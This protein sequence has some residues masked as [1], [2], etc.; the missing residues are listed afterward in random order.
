MPERS[1]RSL[2]YETLEGRQVAAAD[3]TIP[4]EIRTLIQ[5]VIT[6]TAPDAGWRA[7][8]GAEATSANLQSYANHV[9][10]RG[11]DGMVRG[12]RATVTPANPA[13]TVSATVFRG[14]DI[15]ATVPVPAAGVFT[16]E[17][18]IGFTDVLF[19]PSDRTPVQ[20]T[21]L[22]ASVLASMQDAS[23]DALTQFT[24]P[25]YALAAAPSVPMA[26]NVAAAAKTLNLLSSP[27]GNGDKR[28]YIERDPSQYT[29]V[30]INYT[31]GSGSIAWVG[32]IMKT[33]VDYMGRETVTTSGF[34]E[35]YVRQIDPNT[36]VIAPG[37]PRLLSF[38][39]WMVGATGSVSTKQGATMESVLPPAAMGPETVDVSM[40][41][42]YEQHQ[43]EGVFPGVT[44]IREGE[45]PVFSAPGHIANVKY[46]VRNEAMGGGTLWFDVYAGWYAG[47]PERGTLQKTLTASIGGGQSLMLSANVRAPSTPADATSDRPIVSI[48]TRFAGG[49]TE[50]N[51]RLGKLARH[52]PDGSSASDRDRLAAVN[53]RAVDA[54]MAS[55]HP[56]IVAAREAL[57]RPGLESIAR[58]TYEKAVDAI[59]ADT[60]QDPTNDRDKGTNAGEG[61]FAGT[62]ERIAT[63]VSPE[64]FMNTYLSARGKAHYIHLLKTEEEFMNL[65]AYQI[66]S[67]DVSFGTFDQMFE[68]LF[69][70]AQMELEPLDFKPNVNQS[71]VPLIKPG[72]GVLDQ[73]IESYIPTIPPE[74]NPW[75]RIENEV[76]KL[77]A[78]EVDDW[79]EDKIVGLSAS[80]VREVTAIKRKAVW[81]ATVAYDVGQEV[82]NVAN[83]KVDALADL[84]INRMQPVIPMLK[85]VASGQEYALKHEIMKQ[86][87]LMEYQPGNG[88]HPGKLV[89]LIDGHLQTIDGDVKKIGMEYVQ[90]K[91]A[92]YEILQ[93]RV[94]LAFEPLLHNTFLIIQL[95]LEV[96]FERLKN[97]GISPNSG[98]VNEIDM[99]G[100]S[101][102]GGTAI[103][104]ASELENNPT[105]AG[106]P[107]KL[108]VIDAVQL[109]YAGM[110]QPALA[111]GSV[112]ALFNRYQLSSTVT[113]EQVAESVLLGLTPFDDGSLIDNID[114][115]MKHGVPA[116]GTY[117]LG[118]NWAYEDQKEMTFDGVHHLSIDDSDREQSKLMLDELVSF[119][120]KKL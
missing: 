75:V 50:S 101:W 108:G 60:D 2:S 28:F 68:H 91:L 14:N 24:S 89:I 116:H 22:E 94:V 21:G 40:L 90:S 54:L 95:T 11:F 109:G 84:T 3:T 103:D 10:L 93:F 52:D 88:T 74:E 56:Q 39:T 79:I 61:E 111:A 58:E 65:G 110:S 77:I 92:G 102:G 66:A 59:M 62:M 105:Y 51:S 119:L 15:I 117:I 1:T 87:G 98:T 112:D 43:T 31:K 76:N 12:V 72:K 38:G 29:M 55:N 36:V 17:N 20:V 57:G 9:N 114:L 64:Q 23:P 100:Y 86:A 30:R 53:R 83:E 115:L 107:V 63:S 78:A 47:Q 6:L 46:Q 34:P 7:P 18:D 33:G 120:T 113:I 49:Q 118:R 69:G 13:M 41:K 25:S 48:V 42:M 106:I 96:V 99:A 85:A 97:Q 70:R 37:A 104:M 16:Y 19:R 71:T 67:T 82:V 44:E 26:T 81:A 45:S 73:V 80:L 4:P 35:G 32:T 8:V 27:S 5:D